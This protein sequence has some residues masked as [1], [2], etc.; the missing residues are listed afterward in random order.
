MLP[1]QYNPDIVVPAFQIDI[2][3]PGYNASESKKLIINPL[4]NKLFEIEWVEHIYG[5]ASKDFAS[6]MVSFFVWED[7][8]DA[9]TRLYNKIQSNKDQQPLGIQNM[10]ITAIDPDEIPI[11][12][13]AI[14]KNTNNSWNYFSG[15]SEND[16]I[17]L[18]KLALE[19]AENIKHID[20]ISNIYVIWWQKENI[21]IRLDP[22]LLEAKNI[23]M[24]QVIDVIKKNNI[25]FPWGNINFAENQASISINGNLNTVA[26][27]KKLLL[28]RYAGNPVYLEDVANI[29]KWASN[30]HSQTI[31]VDDS[32]AQNTIYLGIAKK[33]WKN[34][35]LVTEK[36]EKLLSE[37]SQKLPSWYHISI[38]QDEWLTAKTTTNMLLINLIQS[39]LIVVLI[40]TVFLWF[41]NS[42]NVAISIPLTLSVIFIFALIIGDNVNRITLFALILVLWMLV[43]DATVVVENVN[44]NLS[45]RAK[46]HKTKLDAIFDAIKE[47]ELGVILSTITRLLAFGAMFFVTGMMWLYMWPIPKYAILAMIT[48]TFVALSINPFLAHVLSKDINL[49]KNKPSLHLPSRFRGGRITSQSQKNTKNSRI[50][51]IIQ[52]PILII[53]TSLQKIKQFNFHERF[54]NKYLWLLNNYLWDEEGKLTKRNKF[55]K[56]FFII[57]GIIV[58]LP[59]MFGIFRIRMLPK[60]DQN[61]IYLRLDNRPDSNIY[62]NIQIAEA[63]QNFLKTYQTKK[64]KNIKNEKIIENSSYRIWQAPLPDFS[65][66]FR[67]ASWRQRENQISIRINLTDKKNRNLS[68]EEFVMTLRPELKKFLEEKYPVVQMRLLEDPPG[69]PVRATFLIKVSWAET[70]KYERLEEFSLRLEDK[71]DIL[72]EKDEVKDIYTSKERYRNNFQLKLDH[73]LLS[74]LGLTAEQIAYTVNTAFMGQKVGIFQDSNNR[75]ASYIF[76]TMDEQYKDN[77]NAFQYIMITNTQWQKIPLLEVAKLSPTQLDKWIF[78]DDKKSTVYIY[79]EMGNNSVIYPFI[80]IYNQLRKDSF[81]EWKYSLKKIDFYGI[82]IT[83]NVSWEDIRISFGWEREVTIDTFRDLWIAMVVAF[84]AIYFMMVAQFK[85]FKIAWAIMVSF[86]L[87]FIGVFPGFTILYLIS[88]EY[89]SATSMIGVIALAGIVVWNAII[90]V[91]YINILLNRWRTK[92]WAI[93][94]AARTRL[95]PIFVTSLTTIL[96]ATTILWDPVRSGLALAIIFGLTSSAALTPII[97]PILLYDK[98]DEKE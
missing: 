40:L 16:S 58:V 15:I 29:S 74:S 82:S 96:G 38:I 72:L 41:R 75:E 56:I 8:E 34:A 10:Q 97:I 85:K 13:I 70:T 76:V 88:N 25:Q 2:L 4:E 24:L 62:E 18:R 83:D 21:N 91:E 78:S 64:D 63:T 31:F 54:K 67:G 52:K 57:L 37:I 59:P 3:V 43:D 20:E 80:D 36:A 51:K 84:I 73:E 93:I 48:S 17:F 79:G 77:L 81:R 89:F 9:T 11:F 30:F 22:M 23:D 69:P 12:S 90:L 49:S 39:I 45:I 35:V 66:T 55:R 98:I 61:Q 87:G 6:I 44:R 33:K 28:S 65:N 86:L 27:V 5:Y 92:K 46:T 53:K 71:L 26:K 42:I 7:K 68:S 60:S 32:W 50:K 14:S 94:D 1:K 47:V 19:V 95:K